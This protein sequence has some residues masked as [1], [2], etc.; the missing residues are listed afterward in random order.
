[1]TGSLLNSRTSFIVRELLQQ[2]EYLGRWVESPALE[3]LPGDV[4]VP[5]R[6]FEVDQQ[7]PFVGVSVQAAGEER[8]D[9]DLSRLSYNVIVIFVCPKKH[10]L[11]TRC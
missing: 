3:A 11:V 8:R 7:E 6:P 2:L 1:M 5:E 4:A 10:N 9:E